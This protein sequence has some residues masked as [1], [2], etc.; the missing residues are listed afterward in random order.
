M[1][2]I[3][4]MV[5][6]SRAVSGHEIIYLYSLK[7]YIPMEF[8]ELKQG[9]RTLFFLFSFLFAQAIGWL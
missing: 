4:L 1:R 6:L 5:W 9:K 2:I 3:G 7:V 8:K